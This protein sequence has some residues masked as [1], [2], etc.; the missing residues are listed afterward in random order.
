MYK[1]MLVE[2]E[3]FI[4]NGLKKLVEELVRGYRVI[5]EAKDGEEALDLLQKV[6]PDLLITD[7]RMPRMDGLHFIERLKEHG[8]T[9]PIVIISGHGEFEYA[10][11]ALRLQ[12]ADYL[13]KPID[14]IELAKLLEKLRLEL[15]ELKGP[16]QTDVFDSVPQDGNESGGKLKLIRQVKEIVK[17]NLGGD[18]SLQQVADRVHLHYKYL[19][20]LFK[21]ETGENF[22]DY[23]QRLRIMKAKTLLLETN[24][25]MYEIAEMCGFHNQKYFM[26]VFKQATGMTTRDFRNR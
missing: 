22:S 25:R 26:S 4:R 19:S 5:A 21:T 20:V 12:V 1:V 17:E 15:E 6:T 8:Y 7:I 13:L 23:V 16:G 10:K 9:F 2:D 14:R 18:L 11:K 24:L 3:S